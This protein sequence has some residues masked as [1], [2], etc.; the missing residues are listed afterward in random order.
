MT[1]SEA[2]QQ[3]LEVVNGLKAKV[4]KLE[5]SINIIEAS[6]KVLNNRAAGLMK[7]PETKQQEQQLMAEAPQQV[8]VTLQASAA[9][10]SDLEEKGILTYKKVFGKLKNNA[11]DPIDGVL[12]KVYDKNNEVCATTETDLVGYFELM[13][14]PGRYVAEYTKAGFKTVNKTFEVDKNAKEIEVK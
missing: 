1:G 7:A 4:D 5:G 6:I 11:G 9:S 3:I 13:L 14:R 8:Q 10:S 2:I 12:L